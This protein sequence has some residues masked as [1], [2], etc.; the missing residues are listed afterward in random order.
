MA[1]QLQATSFIHNKEN[2]ISNSKLVAWQVSDEDIRSCIVKNW[3]NNGRFACTV[4][5]LSGKI[6]DKTQNSLHI[7]E[8]AEPVQREEWMALHTQYIEKATM[9]GRTQPLSLLLLDATD[10]IGERLF[11]EM[12]QYLTKFRIPF[13]NILAL[14]TDNAD[15]MVSNKNSFFTRLEG[16]YLGFMR[17]LK[18]FRAYG[19]KRVLN[20]SYPALRRV[21]YVDNRV[22]Y[23]TNN[24]YDRPF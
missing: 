23:G 22:L 24:C 9:D 13:G 17:D 21:L 19:L 3:E 15:V 6:T 2:E 16:F 5:E 7:D 14:S 11:I 10:T 8:F 20:R 4:C 18:W 1:Q 12:Q